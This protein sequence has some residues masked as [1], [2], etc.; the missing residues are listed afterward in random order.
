MNKLWIS[1]EEAKAYGNNMVLLDLIEL[2]QYFSRT[3]IL[4]GQALN[5]IT[6]NRRLNV[7][8]RKQEK[9]RRKMFIKGHGK[10]LEKPTAD[11]FDRL[12]RDH[13]KEIAEVNREYKESYLHEG[14]E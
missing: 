6:Y 12:S 3:A 8:C 1:L 11:L 10:L 2:T 14:S 4:V 9:K 13:V 7:L 5:I